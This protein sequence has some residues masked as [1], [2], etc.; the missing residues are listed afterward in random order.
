MIP[1]PLVACGPGQLGQAAAGCRAAQQL[2]EYFDGGP[3]IEAQPGRP[4]RRL[5]LK[6]KGGWFKG[7]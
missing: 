1:F 6:K 3:R 7:K 4:G 2:A 5:A